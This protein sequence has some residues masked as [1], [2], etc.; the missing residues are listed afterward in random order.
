[1][2][3]LNI[4]KSSPATAEASESAPKSDEPSNHGKRRARAVA[5]LLDNGGAKPEWFGGKLA[6][7]AL[8]I[9]SLRERGQDALR[10][11]QGPFIKPKKV[12]RWLLGRPGFAARPKL[13]IES[14]SS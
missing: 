14:S 10:M 3:Y 13:G 4:R 1:M 6:P 9:S 7:G 2:A 5:R 8:G 12:P 11:V